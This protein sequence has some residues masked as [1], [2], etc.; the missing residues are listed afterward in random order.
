[1]RCPIP[2]GVLDNQQVVRVLVC[3]RA[4]A[5]ALAARRRVLV[6]CAAGRNRSALVASMALARLTRMG[7]EDLVRLM[8]AKR[9][10]QALSNPYFR[11][12]L[13][14]IVGAGLRR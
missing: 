5:D 14:R 2:D 12:L 9:D 8:R 3:A 11:E 4:V 1:M 6:T 13:A 10:P 7:A